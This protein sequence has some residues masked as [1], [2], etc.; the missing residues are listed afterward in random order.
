M[1]VLNKTRW[2]SIALPMPRPWRD[3]L[4]IP[5]WS[6]DWIGKNRK[7][8]DDFVAKVMPF[9]FGFGSGGGLQTKAGSF[10]TTAGA[11]ATTIVVTGAGF[12]PKAIIFFWSGT[13]TNGDVVQSVD[14]YAGMSFATLPTERGGIAISLDDGIATSA[15][16]QRTYNDGV[17]SEI[18]LATGAEL[19]RLDLQSLDVD[20]FTLVVDDAFSAAFDDAR[21]GYLMIGG[22]SLTNVKTGSFQ[23]AAATGNQAVTG[24]GFRPDIVFFLAT[25]VTAALP[26]SAANAIQAFGV[27]TPTGQFVVT[28][29]DQ[30][31]VVGPFD[32]GY[33]YGA[34]CLAISSLTGVGTEASFVSMD[35]DG[36]TFNRTVGTSQQRVIYLALKG[37]TYYVGDA[38]TRTDGN[39]IP[40]TGMAAG[41]TGGLVVSSV[42]PED[43]VSTIHNEAKIS[44]GAFDSI[45]SR[46]STL[47]YGEYANR[48]YNRSTQ[49][50][51][52]YIS[53][54]TTPAVDGQ[55][56]VK[57]INSDGVTFVMDDADPVAR[58]F[59]YV[60]FG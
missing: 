29:G 47:V 8:L 23:L 27:M 53:T 36:F 21:I 19:G 41:P 22:S 15:T 18:T 40:V 7:K 33:G 30:D 32:T 9:P 17:V 42:M 26:A 54:D 13:E 56:D 44:V 20:G 58:F 14:T 39:D 46:I 2:A 38:L 28:T 4:G 37:G 43:A 50:D 6:F 5:D 57:T 12:T 35:A 10:Q 59:G 31:G 25:T 11:A 24:V 52:V 34:Q 60:L 1:L 48:D 55:M 45:S 51:G 16:D 3:A 49:G